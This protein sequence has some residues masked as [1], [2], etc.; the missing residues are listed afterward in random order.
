MGYS[1]Y[2]RMTVNKIR[3]CQAF[4]LVAVLCLWLA[5]V[6]AAELT[7][8]KSVLQTQHHTTDIDSMLRARVTRTVP[9]MSTRVEFIVVTEEAAK[10]EAAID[11]AIAEMERII[12]VMSE[13]QADSMISGVNQA[14]GK[15]PVHI[16]AELF[17]LLTAAQ[18]LSQQTQGKF[19]ITFAS[20]GKLWDFRKAQIPTPAQINRAIRRIDYTRLKLDRKNM[21]AFITHPGTQIGLGGIAKG[22]AVDRASDILRQQG[23]GEFSVNAGGDLYAEGQHKN[24]LWQVGIQNPRNTD[25]LIALLPIANSAVATSGDYERFFIHDGKRYSHIIDPHTGYPA[26][27]CQAVTVLAPRAFMADAIATGVFVLGVE[28]GLALVNRLAGVEAV[29]IDAQGKMHVSTGLPI[30]DPSE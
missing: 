26:N 2:L 4:I 20:V 15:R 19:D 7:P 24:G 25:Q 29:V 28:K 22:Y 10:A 14:A 18:Q 12:L 13:W 8:V 3:L 9:M 23:F 27:H 11:L 6:L 30:L 21:T 17:E 16:S 1:S 5:D